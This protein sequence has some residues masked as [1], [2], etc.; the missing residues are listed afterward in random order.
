MEHIKH[1]QEQDLFGLTLNT[2]Y[3]SL[4]DIEADSCDEFL[5]AIPQDRISACPIHS[6]ILSNADALPVQA[7]QIKYVPMDRYLAE[8]LKERYALVDI[9]SLG[10][11]GQWSRYF[12]CLCEK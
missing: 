6:S 4:P 10:S 3:K 12:D 1:R 5:E 9:G 11:G 8:G 2:S 7:G